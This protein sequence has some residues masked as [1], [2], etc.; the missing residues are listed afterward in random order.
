MLLLISYLILLLSLSDKRKAEDELETVN[1]KKKASV[2]KAY[3]S[4]S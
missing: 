2:L 4:S 1:P 3:F